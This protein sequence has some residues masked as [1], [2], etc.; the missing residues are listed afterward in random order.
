M[1][2]GRPASVAQARAWDGDAA[3]DHL[4]RL[5]WLDYQEARGQ[6]L[7]IEISHEETS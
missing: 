6:L 2:A 3:L 4:E 7:D 5:E 1:P